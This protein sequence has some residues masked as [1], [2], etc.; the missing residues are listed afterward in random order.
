MAYF[1]VLFV[2]NLALPIPLPIEDDG[3]TVDDRAEASAYTQAQ[4]KTISQLVDLECQVPAV[5]DAERNPNTV[6]LIDGFLK[7]HTTDKLP[8]VPTTNMPD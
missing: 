1:F 8:S 2:L 7:I 4:H 6:L 3:L 5:S